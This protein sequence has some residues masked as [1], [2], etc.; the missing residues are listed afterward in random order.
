MSDTLIIQEPS[1]SVSVT[2]DILTVNVTE[3]ISETLEIGYIQADLGSYATK[4]YVDAAVSGGYGHIRIEGIS[5]AKVEYISDVFVVSVT[6]NYA[7]ATSTQSQ[8]DAISGALSSAGDVHMSDLIAETNARIS[9]D[10]FLYFLIQETSGSGSGLVTSV[11]GMTGDVILDIPSI[12]G[13]ASEVFVTNLVADEAA[14]RVAGDNDLLALIQATS[15]SGAG[16]VTSVNGMT[17][18]VILDIPSISGLA[19]EAY[20]VAA[21][22]MT[23]SASNA[24]TDTAIDAI[25]EVP[26]TT[27]TA[28]GSG[29]A[30]NQIGINNF[31]IEITGSF[32]DATLRSEVA[33][34]SATQDARI[35]AVEA[36]PI[37]D[38]FLVDS[39]ALSGALLV[40][41]E[42]K[43]DLLHTHDISG[44]SGLQAALDGKLNTSAY[45]APDI[46][47]AEVA[48]VSGSL[49]T[50]IS[51][52]AAARANADAILQSRINDM[53]SNVFLVGS[54]A[55]SAGIASYMVTHSSINITG[56][57][58]LAQ[59]TSPGTSKPLASVGISNRTATQFTMSLD[60][61]PLEA[62]YTINYFIS[63]GKNPVISH[64]ISDI[65]IFTTNGT[66]IAPSGTGWQTVSVIAFGGGQGGASGRTTAT[67]A[68]STGGGGGN[69]AWGASR[70]FAFSSM[71]TSAAVIVGAGGAGGVANG[72]ASN[73]AG[74]SGGNT[75]FHGNYV[76]AY[77]GNITAP[78]TVNIGRGTGGAGGVGAAG[79]AGGKA[80]GAAG[81]GG[82]AGIAAGTPGTAYNGGAGGDSW[83][84]NTP[85][86]SPGGTTAGSPAIAG[87]A[88]ISWWGGAG[89]GGG[90]SSAT[91][92]AA[93]CHG[94]AASIYGA[95]GGG[96]GSVRSGVAGNG[97]AGG[98]GLCV[99]ITRR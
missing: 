53:T 10:N 77:A 73:I 69:G 31:T 52:E 88:A 33:S 24:Y 8:I 79:T 94:A 59:L 86:Q 46:F 67:S 66:W 19:S 16:L 28:D 29:L 17:G 39:V 32:G 92:V 96:G 4:A 82:G 48:T 99:V 70:D 57:Y 18:D 12:S 27:I 89:G 63:D 80:F 78:Y 25:P 93:Q 83:G 84:A 34:I 50:A 6:G 23:L 11:N 75:T 45:V 1:Y 21:A 91:T 42:K 51:N 20:V 41:I 5:G 47:R 90:A 58:V 49:S 43:S 2:G 81:G 7:D 37:A 97:G 40:E 64:G 9:G 61:A 60:T 30:V 98:N 74:G 65:Q 54:V 71:P 62:G 26:L 95:G 87:F 38:W 13:L 14:F 76:V 15:G 68:A 55:C 35:A 72:T 44:V 22:T 3:N 36:R 85:S 56:T